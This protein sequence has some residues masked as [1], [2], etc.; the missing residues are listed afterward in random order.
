[1]ELSVRLASKPAPMERSPKTT[2]KM[3][4]GIAVAS[5]PAPGAARSNCD[6]PSR[7]EPDP[8]AKS[9]RPSASAVA[10]DSEIDTSRAHDGAHDERCK[11][12]CSR[13]QHD[14]G[15][16]DDSEQQECTFEAEHR[17]YT[18]PRSYPAVRQTGGRQCR[19]AEGEGRPVCGGRQS[20]NLLDDKGRGRDP[21]PHRG[22]R[23]CNAQHG[24]DER[25]VAAK[26]PQ[27]GSDPLESAGVP[28]SGPERFRTMTIATTDIAIAKSASAASADP[29]PRNWP[30]TPPAIG[31]TI[32]A[33]PRTTASRPQR[34]L[35]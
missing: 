29:Q 8:R 7:A 32:G 5:P 19:G 4:N 17:P 2:S 10:F 30:S 35:S 33:S 26:P 14:D 22:K 23:C 31:A 24:S 11:P 28:L 9:A 25:P 15:E 18:D 6:A 13:H 27:V 21:G 3:S 1:M 34:G 20:E 16:A 12:E